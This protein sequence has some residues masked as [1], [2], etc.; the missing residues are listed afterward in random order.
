[1]QILRNLYQFNIP[2]KDLTIIYIS[3]I[4][5][6]L[7]ES[8]VLWHSSLTVQQSTNHEHVQRIA[9]RIILKDQY[10]DYNQFLNLVQLE[11]LEYRREKLCLKFALS[12]VKSEQNRSMFPIHQNYNNGGTRFKEK[13]LVQ[14]ATT[15]RLQNSAIPYM[16]TL[17]NKY[18]HP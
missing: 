3:Y 11:T 17:L 13:F 9:L 14:N 1:M 8:C 2:I 6:Y 10:L 7:E 12:S 4:R 18:S 16:Q 15:S 5:C